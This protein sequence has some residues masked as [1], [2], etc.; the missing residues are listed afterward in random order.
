M[1]LCV[2]EIVQ[3]LSLFAGVTICLNWLKGL[4]FLIRIL[5]HN[6]L[7]TYEF[8]KEWFSDAVANSGTLPDLVNPEKYR[9]E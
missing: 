2:V 4:I 3:V 6:Q 5:V 1:C 7:K 8:Y 9:S